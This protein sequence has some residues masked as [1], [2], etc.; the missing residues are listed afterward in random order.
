MGW[1]DNAYQVTDF[2]TPSLQLNVCMKNT[3]P[4]VSTYGIQCH[5][6]CTHTTSWFLAK[7]VKGN[8]QKT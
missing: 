8:V 7:R 6:K 2:K 3:I 4:R 5:D 1:I